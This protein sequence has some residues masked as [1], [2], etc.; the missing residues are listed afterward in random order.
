MRSDRE[1]HGAFTRLFW[2]RWFRHDGVHLNPA[3]L[4]THCAHLPWHRL[5]EGRAEKAM[6]AIRVML[7][8]R[9]AVVRDG[10]RNSVDAADLVRDAVGEV[11]VRLAVDCVGGVH[12]EHLARCLA[13]GGTLV[14]YGSMSGERCMISPRYFVFNDLTLRGF[15]LSQGF[16]RAPAERRRGVFAELAGLV[17]D[18]TLHARVQDH[19]S[20]DHVAD[21]VRAAHAGARSGKIIIEPNGPPRAAI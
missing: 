14:N 9:A 3:H 5:Q 17:A 4:D 18:G 20:I 19:Y 8:P 7:A 13:A 10:R 21:A 16:K 6:H 1:R 15:W 12:T 11:H 2:P